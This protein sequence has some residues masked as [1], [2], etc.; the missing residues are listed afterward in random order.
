[1]MGMACV[2]DLEGYWLATTPFLAGDAI[3]VADLLVV[4]ELTQLRMLNGALKV[5]PATADLGV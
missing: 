5:F 4:M 2:Q 3:S 1:M